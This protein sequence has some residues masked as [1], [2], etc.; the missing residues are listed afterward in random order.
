MFEK[1]SPLRTEPEEDFKQVFFFNKIWFKSIDLSIQKHMNTPFVNMKLSLW[2]NQ[3]D[4]TKFAY[5]LK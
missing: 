1:I 2:E 3:T 5:L 4:S